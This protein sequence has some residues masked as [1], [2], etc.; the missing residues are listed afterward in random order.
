LLRNKAIGGVIWSAVDNLSNQLINF[1][2]GI[3]L[4]R[5]LSPEEFGLIGMIAIFIGI[6]QIL[7]NSGIGDALIKK[8]DIDESYYNTAFIFNACISLILYLILFFT[9]PYIADFYERPI[10]KDII[11]LLS[12]TL[13]L[14]AFTLVQRSQITKEIKFKALAKVSL[15]STILSGLIAIVLAY[16]D[17][18]VWSLVWKN[19]IASAITLLVFWKLTGWMPR[20][21]FD[22]LAFKDMF[23]FGSRLMLLGLIDTAYNNTYFLIIGKYY[24]ASDLGQYTRAE[25]FKRLPSNTLT[26]IVQRVTYPLLSEIQD[27]NVR[28]KRSYQKIL[29]STML[30]SIS[31]MFILSLVAEELTITLMGLQ[32]ETAGEYLKVLCFSGLFYPLDALNSNIL[33]IKNKSGKILKIGI[34]RKILAV[35]LVIIMIMVGIKCFLY[36]L[37]LHQLISFLMI[38]HYSKQLIN[39][40]TWQ[41][42]NDFKKFVFLFGLEYVLIHFCFSFLNANYDFSV[43]SILIIKLA[44]YVILIISTLILIRDKTFLFLK[45]NFLEKIWK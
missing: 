36:S 17:Y 22:S 35:P 30:I 44:V 26:Q 10:L 18:G 34:Y 8:K 2:I 11:R 13:I 7:I 9:A 28:L 39:Y 4:A 42:I 15:I 20:L 16:F 6:S 32:W 31:G 37:I 24:S 3:I 29:K 21:K 19:V 27:D 40:S 41:Q 38:S 45:D 25:T 23:G 1:V 33:K 5:L 14:N 12:F 43:L